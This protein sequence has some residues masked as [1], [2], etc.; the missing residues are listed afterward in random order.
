MEREELGSTMIASKVAIPHPMKLCAKRSFIDV[1]IQ[2]KSLL[3][4]SE[5]GANLIFVLILSKEDYEDV[6]SVYEF[7]LHIIQKDYIAQVTQCGS[8]LEYQSM[9][10]Y[11]LAN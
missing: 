3:W 4:D 11:I 9:V 1:I 10:E 8:F 7:M 2:P 5:Q 6:M